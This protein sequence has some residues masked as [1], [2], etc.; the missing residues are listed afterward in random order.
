MGDF[1][2][3][4]IVKTAVRELTTPIADVTTFNTLVAG[5][6][7]GNPWSCT[8]YEI[9]GVA[10]PAV[11]KTREGY[12][13]RIEYEDN[14][15]KIVG[16]VNARAPTVAGFTSGVTAILADTGLTTAMGGDPVH[17]TE[18]DSFSATLKCHH[19]NGEIYTVTFTRDQVRVSSYS[20]D[21]IL[22]AIETW[23]DTKPELA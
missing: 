7:S 21:A 1:V 4:S 14:E 9:G 18:E 10:Q 15:A 6:I 17:V 11:A 20:D 2:Q 19:A 5:V 13:A 12:T 3:Q 16:Y 8:A 23:A 22:T